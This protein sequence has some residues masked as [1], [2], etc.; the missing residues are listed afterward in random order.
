[1][2]NFNIRAI[3]LLLL[4]FV[5]ATSY[6]TTTEEVTKKIEEITANY[7]DTKGIEVVSVTKGNGLELIKMMLKKQFGKE[8]MRGVTSITVIDYS[9]ATEEVS[10][11]LRKDLDTFTSILEEFDL[12]G[13]KDF[14][15]NDYV[16][17]FAHKAEDGTLSDFVVAM[18]KDS[19]E[20]VVYMAGK[21][22][23][24]K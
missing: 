8:F 13:N 11:S 3:L 22:I 10:N 2:K 20:M 24:E 19:L 5:C 9:D 14:S 18:E 17:C 7:K 1:M 15:Q 23:V 4:V 21:I 12:S 16:R 6:A